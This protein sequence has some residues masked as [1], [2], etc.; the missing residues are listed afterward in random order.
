[1][2][3]G[4]SNYQGLRWCLVSLPPSKAHPPPPSPAGLFPT[5]TPRLFPPHYT[6]SSPLHLHCRPS[7]HTC[8]NL[9]SLHPSPPLHL[10]Q[11]PH[12]QPLTPPRDPLVMR[13]IAVGATCVVSLS[14]TAGGP[15]G[16][17][18]WGEPRLEGH[19]TSSSPRLFTFCF[20]TSSS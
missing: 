12:N 11:A 1:M 8:T 7:L 5:T 13:T 14:S 6:S 10:T 3:T 16:W 4:A 19:L 9:G 20:F 17:S 15:E 2:I 18:S